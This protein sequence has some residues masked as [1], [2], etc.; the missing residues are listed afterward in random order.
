MT[1]L[2]VRGLRVA[3]GAAEVVAGVDLSVSVGE[4]VTVLGPNGAGKTS[5]LRAISGLV[6]YSGS[7]R[8][9]GAEIRAI[10]TGQAVRRGLIHVP[11]G[12]RVFSG[13]TVHENLLVGAGASA[14]R[15]PVYSVAD[16]Y[17]MFPALVPLRGRPGWTLSGGEQQIVAI[18]RALLAAPRLLL[19][20]EPSLGLAP[21]VTRVVFE[22]LRVVVRTTSVLLVEQ[23]TTLALQLCSRGLVLVN[24]R[25][26][27]EGVNDQL[28][29]RRALLE[30][31]LGQ[32]KIAADVDVS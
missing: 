8:F 22:A 28:S 30:S 23:N 27:M 5:T 29:G 11:E 31:Y 24:G 6:P 14:G 3:Y 32:S 1:L 25:V 2:E 4:V 7:I 12:R 18:G 16:V 13:L 10:G 26:A 19:L 21:R 9:D 17:E 15:R 20:D